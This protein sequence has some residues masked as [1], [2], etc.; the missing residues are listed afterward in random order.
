MAAG[1]GTVVVTLQ[2]K[3]GDYQRWHEA[4]AQALIGDR[5]ETPPRR[6]SSDYE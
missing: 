6:R 4:A 5:A 1:V 2:V 3:V